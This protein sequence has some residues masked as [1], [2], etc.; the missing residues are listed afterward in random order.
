M[1]VEQQSKSSW[2]ETGIEV[3]KERSFIGFRASM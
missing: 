2:A 1:V 3:Q